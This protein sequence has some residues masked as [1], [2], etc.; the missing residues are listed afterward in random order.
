M[1]PPAVGG[2]AREDEQAASERVVSR[3]YRQHVPRERQEYAARR[4]LFLQS[5]RLSTRGSDEEN[6]EATGMRGR[7]ARRLRDAGVAGKA[8]AARAASSARDA[9]RLW[10]G[11]GLGR[12]WRGWRRPLLELRVHGG[13]RHHSSLVGLG[14]GPFGCFGGRRPS[15]EYHFLE[16]FA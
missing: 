16:G 8:A 6:E 14:L 9:A 13:A 7:V 1:A 4:A 11:T 12:A 10:F 2:W 3:Q 5:Y 15:R